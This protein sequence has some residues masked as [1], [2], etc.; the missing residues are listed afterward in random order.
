LDIFKGV[1]KERL[2][3]LSQIAIKRTY[4]PAQTILRQ[5]EEPDAIYFLVKGHVDLYRVP[6]THIPS[7]EKHLK[8]HAD[9]AMTQSQHMAAVQLFGMM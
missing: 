6:V 8:L 5:G 1:E 9:T 2:V 3:Y 7:S 4:S